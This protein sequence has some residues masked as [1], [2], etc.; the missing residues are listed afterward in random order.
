MKDFLQK[1]KKLV[2]VL[3]IV[4]AVLVIC[5]VLNFTLLSLH[6]VEIN[7]KNEP[8]VFAS[9]DSK[10]LIRD[11]KSIK[12]GTSIFAINKKEI[13][14]SLEENN[15]YL[16]VVNIETVFPNKIVIH[17]AE[18]EESYAI[19][20]NDTKYF[21]CDADF[22]VLYIYYSQPIFPSDQSNV[23][24]IT[25]LQNLIKNE[26]RVNPGDFLEFNSEAEILKSIGT[27]L[28]ANNKTVAMQK[29]LIKSIEFTSDI[30]YYT[31]KN[32]PYII[33]T[34][35]NGFKTEIYAL[36]TL[37]AQKFQTMFMCWS[38]IVYNPTVMFKTELSNGGSLD[39][40][41]ENYYLNYTLKIMED[42]NGK[43]NVRLD[44]KS[45]D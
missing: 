15:E 32:Q 30:Y 18:R 33:V 20:A 36:N 25:G 31:A 26:Y 5:V 21:I 16:K 35:F 41:D 44:K 4:F 11:D 14:A 8:T 37:L 6:T 28:L 12:L 9:E 19:K 39:S 24:L 40:I 1:N 29:S 7:F 22:K 10:S 3:G 38:Q 42:L 34:D 2:V 45:Q 13:T 17:C 27:S 43:L 23:I